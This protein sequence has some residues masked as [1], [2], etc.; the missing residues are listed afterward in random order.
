M[1][2]KAFDYAVSIA[3]QSGIQEVIFNRR[4]WVHS[5]GEY[6]YTGSDPHTGHVHIGL[7]RCGAANFDI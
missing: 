7:N 1:I 5:K 2:I 3:C 4:I 6:H